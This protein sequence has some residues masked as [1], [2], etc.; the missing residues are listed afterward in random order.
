MNSRGAASTTARRATGPCTRTAKSLSSAAATP[1][2]RR[3]I[4][5][6]SLHPSV[7]LIH[8]SSFRAAKSAL[9]R[10]FS[11][12]KIDVI[13]DARVTKVN[14]EGYALTSVVIEN[15]KTGQSYEYPTEGAFVYIGVEPASQPYKGQ[16]GAGRGGICPRGGGHENESR[17][18]LC[19][20]RYPQKGCPAGHHRRIRRGC[21]RHHGRAV[22]IRPLSRLFTVRNGYAPYNKLP[23]TALLAYKEDRICS[24]CLFRKR[25]S[26]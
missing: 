20:R 1:Q 22:S 5:W 14:G 24:P 21:R 8:R 9:D 11:N 16:L 2:W 26:N 10:L 15:V 17:W 13:T 25:K 19:R 12:D 23:A 6:Q 7:T 18:R 3:P 4:S